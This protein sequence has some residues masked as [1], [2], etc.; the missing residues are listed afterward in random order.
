[1]FGLGFWEIIA[2]LVILVVMIRPKDLPLFIQRMG[3]LY[4]KIIDLHRVVTGK[5]REVER[6]ARAETTASLI[7]AEEHKEEQND[8]NN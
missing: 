1:M 5:M 4:S 8:R 2:I 7:N 3:R 6:Q